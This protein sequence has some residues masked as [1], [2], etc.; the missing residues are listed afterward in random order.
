MIEVWK[1][2]QVII[3]KRSMVRPCPPAGPLQR[4]L[5]AGLLLLPAS[6]GGARPRAPSSAHPSPRHPLLRPRNTQATGYAG[7]DNPVFYKPNTQMLLG[8]AKVG[9]GAAP[10]GCR[11][12][13]G[14]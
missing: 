2:K 14:R 8:D 9:S 13:D 3:M 7:A 10:G 11:A 1:S 12:G 4:R 5:L 6:A